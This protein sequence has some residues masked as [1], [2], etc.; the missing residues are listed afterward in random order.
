MKYIYI[1]ENFQYILQLNYS[2]YGGL[3]FNFNFDITMTFFKVHNFI[4]LCV[5]NIVSSFQ[6]ST[7]NPFKKKKTRPYF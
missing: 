1:L 2:L 4:F 5:T 3:F 7:M 6:K